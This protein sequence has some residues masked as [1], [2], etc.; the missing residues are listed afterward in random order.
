MARTRPDTKELLAAM[1][2][3]RGLAPAELAPLA[4]GTTVRHAQRGEVIFNRGEPCVGVHILVYG[5]IKLAFVS[6]TGYEKVVEIVPA[7]RS[8]G[9]APLFSASPYLMMAQ[10]LVD[11][12]LLHVDRSAVLAAIE[13]HPQFTSKLLIEMAHRMHRLISDVEGY[14]LQSGTERL[15]AFLLRQQPDSGSASA[16]RCLTLSTSKAVI[17]SRINVTPEHL[18]RIL[19][20]LS[21]AGLIE[22]DGRHVRILDPDRLRGYRG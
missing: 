1:P 21:D 8:F 4:A 15:V 16:P 20:E 6:D 17:A 10:A 2:L 5:Q 7:G 11:S 9:E 3:F 14:S 19:H 18:S 12:L 13:R 22:V